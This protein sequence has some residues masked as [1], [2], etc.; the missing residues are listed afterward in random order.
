[1]K[2]PFVKM[3]G[4]GND[5]VI[6]DNT[7]A[8]LS[9]RKKLILNIS[10]RKTGVGCDQVIFMEN[11]S[12]YDILMKIYNAD[13]SEAE[14]CGNAARCI[15]SLYLA[16]NRKK[17]VKIETISSLLLGKVEKNNEISIHQELPKQSLSKIIK[18]GYSNIIDLKEIHPLLSKGFIINMGNPHVVFFTSNLKKINLKEVGNKIEKYEA[19]INGINVEI[20]QL[21]SKTKIKIK[22]WER[23]AG[24][25]LSCGSGILAAFYACYK[26]KKCSSNV[27]IILPLGS[28][29][30]KIEGSKLSLTGKA[31]VS[32]LG[33]YNY[34]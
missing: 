16:G 17:E 8:K 7:K 21:L 23:G 28:A 25:T 31:V 27:N 30:A 11:S 22:F 9:N 5:F 18:K 12:R 1:M 13:G 33:E 14:M 26:E 19:F 4:N 3:H 24:E 34:A 20:V 29:N 6:I 10:N 32:F 15:A 2:I